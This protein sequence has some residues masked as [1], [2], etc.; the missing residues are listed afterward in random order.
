M[1]QVRKARVELLP[2]FLALQ[3]SRCCVKGDFGHCRGDVNLSLGAL[4]SWRQT[5]EF[6]N[7][8]RNQ[9]DVGS[10]RFGGETVFDEL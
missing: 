9:R 4:E 5:D 6:L 7:F 3:G 1:I 10:K 2:N 8:L